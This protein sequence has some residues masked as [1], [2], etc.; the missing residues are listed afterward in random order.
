MTV[1]KNINI[2]NKKARFEFEILDKLVAGIQLTGTEIKSIRLSKARITES[3]CE[4]NDRGELFVINMY[5]EEYIYGH[6]FNH[7]PKSERRLLL[8]KKELKNLKKDVE[9]KGNTIV[10][11]R[12]FI[13]DRGF[14][15][16]EI[17]LAKGK[18][19]HDKREVLKDRDNKRDLDRIKKKYK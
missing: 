11:M 7:K 10:P 15:K 8:N 17:A 2:K 12:L 6:Q 3:F 5:I 13:N 1:Q 4:F 16:L 14:A 18:K 9:A 19:T